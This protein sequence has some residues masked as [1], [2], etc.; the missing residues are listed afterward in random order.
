M[1]VE[2]ILMIFFLQGD[3]QS[4]PDLNQESSTCEERENDQ[5]K[6]K[7]KTLQVKFELD[8]MATSMFV[9]GLATRLYRL[10]EPR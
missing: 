2:F 8:L 6:V 4:I 10:E 1:W 3:G 9:I 7:R 5:R